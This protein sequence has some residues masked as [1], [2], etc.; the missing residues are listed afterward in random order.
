MKLF[1]FSKSEIIYFVRVQSYMHPRPSS[2]A[3][4]GVTKR[5]WANNHSRSHAAPRQPTAH[6]YAREGK[7]MCAAALPRARA[8]VVRGLAEWLVASWQRTAA[9]GIWTRR[10]YKARRPGSGT[11]AR[12]PVVHYAIGA[13]RTVVR[14][15]RDHAMS[16][17][18]AGARPGYTPCHL[19]GRLIF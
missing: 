18:L 9:S 14:S 6:P 7:W 19:R 16:C 5:K 8:V 15:L 12:P 10:G 3:H 11:S 13:P 4:G 17:P 1:E 2:Y